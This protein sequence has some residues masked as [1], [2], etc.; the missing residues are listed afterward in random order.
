MSIPTT[1]SAFPSEGLYPSDG[2][3]D[4]GD[5]LWPITPGCFDMDAF[6]PSVIERAKVLAT[7]TLR[8]LTAYR[9]GGCPRTVRPCSASSLHLTSPLDASIWE[10]GEWLNNGCACTDACGC[11][12]L[13][14]VVLSAPV[15]EIHEVRVDGVVLDPSTYRLDG[16]RLVRTD[17]QAWPTS[18]DLTLPDTEPGTFSVTY[19]PGYKV[20]A[21]GTIA[22]GVLTH[23]YAK[24]CSGGHCRLPAGVTQI[25]RQGITMEVGADAFPN[26]RTGIR[27]VD[28]FIERW[29]PHGLRTA[30]R[31]LSPDLQRVR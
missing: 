21:L 10:H 9:V 24:A 3:A 18:Q 22:A 23:E 31:V 8:S 27:E 7:A 19:L 30:P 2:T 11:R 6:E 29:N 1:P 5:C 4:F 14:E 13:S 28:V 25:A 26:Q 16:A 15:G 20:D 17:G 12:A